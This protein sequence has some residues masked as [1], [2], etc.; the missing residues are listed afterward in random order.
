[1]APLLAFAAVAL[2]IWAVF[3]AYHANQP[4]VLARVASRYGLEHMGRVLTGR[5]LQVAVVS[6][7]AGRSRNEV[8]TWSVALEGCPPGLTLEAEGASTGARVAAGERELETGH[9]DFDDM[10]WVQATSPELALEYL[11]DLRCD[12][13]TEA[14][15]VLPEARVAVSQFA[16]RRPYSGE[17]SLREV[18]EGSLQL[19]TDLQVA[20]PQR[21]FR[22]W[23]NYVQRR[24]HAYWALALAVVF[25]VPAG[26]WRYR[27][28]VGPA[29]AALGAGLLFLICALGLVARAPGA[30]T[31]LRIVVRM[32]QVASI[33]GAAVLSR[34]LISPTFALPALVFAAVV[35]AWCYV[36]ER[37]R[38]ALLRVR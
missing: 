19:L 1:M 16:G 30:S 15:W 23:V 26:F 18:L 9:V 2:I 21:R 7:G 38:H 10:V 14:F 3:Y 37:W 20:R 31:R 22:G 35:G 32:L 33:C 34:D 4:R 8:L 6:E 29:V 25:A 17:G 12:A 27:G 36:L 5:G 28:E 13:F 11:T 24:Y